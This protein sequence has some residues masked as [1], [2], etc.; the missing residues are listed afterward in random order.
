MIN[1]G[2]FKF[3]KVIILILAVYI[4]KKRLILNSRLMTYFFRSHEKSGCG[5]PHPDMIF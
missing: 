1:L 3:L 4:H 5:R 2:L